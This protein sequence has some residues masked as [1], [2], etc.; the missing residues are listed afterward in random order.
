M[1]G[2]GWLLGYRRL[3]NKNTVW[4]I[5]CFFWRQKVSGAAEPIKNGF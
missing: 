3:E 4:T 2:R 1:L 5:L